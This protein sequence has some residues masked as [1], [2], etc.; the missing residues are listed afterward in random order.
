ML[1]YKQ[2]INYPIKAYHVIEYIAQVKKRIAESL[3]FTCGEFDNGDKWCVVNVE[4]LLRFILNSP[5]YSR[6]ANLDKVCSLSL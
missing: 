2:G 3:P 5:R 6:F 4:S 1:G